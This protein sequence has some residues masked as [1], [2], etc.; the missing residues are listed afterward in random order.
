MSRRRVRFNLAVGTFAGCGLWRWLLLAM[1]WRR[2]DG[3]SLS[4][5]RRWLGTY[6]LCEVEGIRVLSL[7]E[8]VSCYRH[9]LSLGLLA[10]L[11]ELANLCSCVLAR[12]VMFPVP[13]L[14]E[15]F[16]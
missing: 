5:K 4:S 13:M 7:L 8:F 10:S 6:V 1:H 14:D 3:W 9:A 11:G 2:D 16:M 15:S 12:I